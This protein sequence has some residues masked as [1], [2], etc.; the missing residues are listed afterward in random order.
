MPGLFVKAQL[1][2]KDLRAYRDIAEFPRV[3]GLLLASFASI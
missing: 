3:F 1:P 2:G